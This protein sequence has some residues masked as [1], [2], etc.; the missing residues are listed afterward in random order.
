V[1]TDETSDGSVVLK[2]MK[3]L[4]IRSDESFLSCYIYEQ[5]VTIVM[6]IEKQRSDFVSCHMYYI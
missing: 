1:H 6:Q 4:T 5:Q 2:L 3:T